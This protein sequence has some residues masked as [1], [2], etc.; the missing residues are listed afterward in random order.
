MLSFV[1]FG[2]I[3]ACIMHPKILLVVAIFALAGGIIWLWKLQIAIEQDK[4]AA[5]DCDE[6]NISVNKSDDISL[7][8]SYAVNNDSGIGEL[9]KKA[10]A[11]K[12]AKK[13]EL[14]LQSLAE[15]KA[16]MLKSGISYPIETWCKYPLYLQQAGKFN[17]SIAEFRF[18]LDDLERRARKE[19][20]LDDCDSDS[21]EL[22]LIYYHG[23]ID[24]GRKTI[25][26]KMALA[27]KREVKKSTRKH[28]SINLGLA[29]RYFESMLG[30]P[31]QQ[32]R[33]IPLSGWDVVE[34]LWPLNKLFRLRLRIIKTIAYDSGLEKDADAAIELFVSNGEQAWTACPAGVWRVL[35]ERYIQLQTVALANEA[36]KNNVTVIP[37]GLP[38]SAR[39]P[40][41]MLLL[42]HSM[43]LPFPPS[44]PTQLELPEGDFHRGISHN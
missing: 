23:I 10:T 16:L 25:K 9:L 42:L 15:A 21:K 43:E 44:A 28:L 40:G 22:K 31:I 27:K 30:K 14:A 1:I 12:S 19:S 26:E 39:L 38:D 13:W 32:C 6:K 34:I 18:L 8:I 7:S 3:V 17:E 29:L 36:N 20:R 4:E 5:R 2:V 24:S 41:L 11:Y 37:E 35:L 33:Q